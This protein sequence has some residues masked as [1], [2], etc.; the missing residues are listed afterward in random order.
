MK[1][2]SKILT[3]T[4]K[5]QNLYVINKNKLRYVYNYAKMKITHIKMLILRIKQNLKK[6][7]DIEN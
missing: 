4:I 7:F 1:K 3:N 5:Y 2:F 6:L